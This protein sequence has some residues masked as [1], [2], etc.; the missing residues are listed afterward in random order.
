MQTTE[1][2]LEDWVRE[3]SDHFVMAFHAHDV[4]LLHPYCHIPSLRLTVDGPRPLL[5]RADLDAHWTAAHDH[6]RPLGYANSIL[7]TVDV[8]L[9]NDSAAFVTADCGRYDAAGRELQ[10]FMTSYM[11]GKTADGWRITTWI[12]HGQRTL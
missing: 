7:H 6:L 5:T 9:I 2:Y 1:Q 8:S 12:T 4:S 11:L 3:Y 10:R